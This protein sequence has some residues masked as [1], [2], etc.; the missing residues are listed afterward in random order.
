MSHLAR[1]TLT[2]PTA[3]DGSPPPA[4]A[5][6]V[7]AVTAEALSVFISPSEFV[8]TTPASWD[9]YLELVESLD[10]LR[11]NGTL[12]VPTV[13]H[14][15]GHAAL[16]NLI[17]T[18]VCMD[19]ILTGTSVNGHFSLLGSASMISEYGTTMW[20]GGRFSLALGATAPTLVIEC[21]GTQFYPSLHKKG[22]AWFAFP[23]CLINVLIS[24][25]V[26]T[27]RR[28]LSK[29]KSFTGLQL[30]L[31]QVQ[32]NAVTAQEVRT[33]QY[34]TDEA[35]AGVEIFMSLA[36]SPSNV[37]EIAMDIRIPYSG[38]FGNNIPAWAPPGTYWT[39][40]AESVVRW[41]EGLLD[42]ME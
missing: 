6:D 23:V 21:G 14:E 19:M 20:L 32:T 33:A 26:L 28:R 22:M 7:S 37:H 38:L 3:D 15:L 30:L 16:I 34:R 42:S 18:E 24:G 31:S 40:S 41:A 11:E 2:S 39:V 5:Y 9:V 17:V 10:E 1:P 25:F 27:R 29:L 12:Y 8:F 36:F 35:A 13:S 4:H